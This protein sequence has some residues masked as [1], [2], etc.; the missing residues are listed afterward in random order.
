MKGFL[1]HAHEVVQTLRDGAGW[2][3]EY[4]HDVWR[5]HTLTG[6]T[7]NAGKT[8]DARNRRS[9]TCSRRMATTSAWCKIRPCRCRATRPRPG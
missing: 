1:L 3:V 7:R 5:L 2:D 9:T 4:P 8:S 6:L